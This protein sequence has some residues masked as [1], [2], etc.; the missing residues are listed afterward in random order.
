MITERQQGKTTRPELFEML[1]KISLTTSRKD[2]IE[3]VKTYSRYA[4]FV[5]Y[6]R[7]VFDAR[8]IF[9]LPE[10]RPPFDPAAENAVP[11]S[12]H[13]QNKQLAY[14]VKGLKG[15][16]LSGLKRESMFISLLESIHPADAEAIIL[17]IGKKSGAKGLTEKLVREALPNLLS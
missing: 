1:D 7:C 8:I 3:L 6:L 12:W 11:S 9:A 14:F 4:C 5:D 2:K 10:G 17:M 16:R 15:D 13:R